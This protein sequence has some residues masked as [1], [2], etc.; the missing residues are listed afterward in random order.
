MPGKKQNEWEPIEP[1]SPRQR[2]LQE[3]IDQEERAR[4]DLR[5]KEREERER[6]ETLGVGAELSG[7]DVDVNPEDVAFVGE[8]YPGGPMP[9]PDQDNVD[10]VGRAVG[11]EY[12]DT[13]TL[14]PEGKIERRD[15][16]RWELDPAS[17]EDF[18]ERTTAERKKD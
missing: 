13:E 11:V 8:E 9:S 7:G 6:R 17:A 2:E 18:H 5:A 1:P 4:G 15:E 14:D 10:E 16:H 12:E 3:M